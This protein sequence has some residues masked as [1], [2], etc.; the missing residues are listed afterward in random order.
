MHNITYRTNRK[1]NLQKQTDLVEELAG[2][3]IDDLAIVKTEIERGFRT[4]PERTGWILDKLGFR[5]YYG[6]ASNH[7]QSM[8]FAVAIC[9]LKT[10]GTYLNFKQWANH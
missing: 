7:N 1:L 4:T 9:D 3:A 6:K 2:K 8:R 10:Q 5:D